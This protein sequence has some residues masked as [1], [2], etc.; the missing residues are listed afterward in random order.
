MLSQWQAK[1]LDYSIGRRRERINGGAMAN[2][3]K[4]DPRGPGRNSLMYAWH[5]RSDADF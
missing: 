1:N 4:D 5:G 3:N 2:G